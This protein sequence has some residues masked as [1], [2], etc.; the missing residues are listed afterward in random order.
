MIILTVGIDSAESYFRE[1]AR[2]SRHNTSRCEVKGPL[3][4]ERLRGT[5]SKR[6]RDYITGAALGEAYCPRK[7]ISRVLFL[8]FFMQPVGASTE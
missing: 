4:L 3:P 6:R 8:C 2:A 1:D 7:T 5:K